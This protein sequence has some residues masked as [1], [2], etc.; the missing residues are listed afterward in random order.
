LPARDQRE[1]NAP[2]I[3]VPVPSRG[4]SIMSSAR[5]FTPSFWQQW[6]HGV[7]VVMLVFVAVPAVDQMHKYLLEGYALAT[8][9]AAQA[10][11]SIIIAILIFI[12]CILF[13]PVLVSRTVGEFPSPLL[14][15]S[16]R[17]LSEK[18]RAQKQLFEQGLDRLAATVGLDWQASDFG[19]IRSLVRQGRDREA[20]ELYSQSLAVTGHEANE[21]I[22]KWDEKEPEVKLHVLLRHLDQRSGRHVSP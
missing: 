18:Y 16:L 20:A 4:A 12:L 5:P 1:S 2:D 21:A 7:V 11:A 9:G 19:R 17:D 10:T 13:A 15:R 8:G 6:R 22:K 14:E 3:A